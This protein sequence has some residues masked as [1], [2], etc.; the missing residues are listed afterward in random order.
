MEEILYTV[1]E[2]AKHLRV[3]KKGV[4]QLVKDGSIKSIKIGRVIR[5][6]ETALKKFLTADQNE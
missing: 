1:E 5:I 6:T 4:Y 2:V 3:D